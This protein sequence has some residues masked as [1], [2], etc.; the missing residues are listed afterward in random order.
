MRCTSHQ[1]K[2]SQPNMG[3]GR[4]AYSGGW[5]ACLVTTVADISSPPKHS[6]A[7]GIAGSSAHCSHTGQA[8]LRAGAKRVV[9][10]LSTIYF[11]QVC[12]QLTLGL[13]YV[14]TKLHGASI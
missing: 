7:A 1:R 13:L 5:N 9:H 6:H 3:M 8:T 11:L 10:I 4:C 12:I 14:S 2:N